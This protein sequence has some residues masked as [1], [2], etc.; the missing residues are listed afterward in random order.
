MSKS[1]KATAYTSTPTLTAERLADEIRQD[2]EL[3]HD[4]STPSKKFEVMII[5]KEVELN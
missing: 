2:I 4:S 1:V 5:V 3:K